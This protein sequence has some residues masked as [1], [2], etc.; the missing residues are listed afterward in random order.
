MSEPKDETKSTT[1]AQTAHTGQLARRRRR[2]NGGS[3]KQKRQAPWQWLGWGLLLA[4]TVFFLVNPWRWFIAD[5]AQHLFGSGRL[6]FGLAYEGGSLV[7]GLLLGLAT[8]VWGFFLL[9]D[10][11]NDNRNLYATACPRCGEPS[12]KRARRTTLDKLW[13]ALGIPVRRYICA[14]CKWQGPRIDQ[15]RLRK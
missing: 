9:R 2:K 14:E 6:L 15:T 4:L 8:A 12:L 5:D 1:E 7:L 11:I 3:N 10:R 13:G